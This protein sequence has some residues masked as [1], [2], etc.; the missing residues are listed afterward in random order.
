MTTIHSPTFAAPFP[1]ERGQEQLDEPQ[2]AQGISP[3]ITLA[4]LVGTS[5]A[6]WAAVLLLLLT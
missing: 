6:V 2:R 4:V 5:F 1:L 3:A